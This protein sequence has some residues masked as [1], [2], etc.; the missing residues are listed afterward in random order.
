M[1]STTLDT[2]VAEKAADVYRKATHVAD[3][4]RLLTNRASDAVGDGVHA[5]SRA[6]NRGMERAA[7]LK[8]TT[9][10]RVKRNPLRAI[11]L[12]FGVGVLLGTAVGALGLRRR[13]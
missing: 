13:S 1:A 12:A 4:A 2:C 7:D 6:I 3:E 8:D 10:Y 11:G 9:V 5:A